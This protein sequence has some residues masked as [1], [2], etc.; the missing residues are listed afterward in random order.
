MIL[1]LN[2]FKGAGKDTAGE[3][4]V[5]RYGFELKKFADPL[6]DSCAALFGVGREDWDKW[7][8]IPTTRVKIE[9]PS[10]LGARDIKTFVNLSAREFMQ[11]FGTESHR[12][13]FG[14]DFWVDLCM[15][16][17]DPEKKTVIT[18]V[19][20]ENEFKAVRAA[21]GYVVRIER[22]E[23]VLEDDHPSEVA[24]DWTSLDFT[25][26]NDGTK[27]ELY[28]ALDSLMKYLGMEVT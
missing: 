7:K 5:E 21:K 6:Y 1:G 20:F 8:N 17:I 27:K 2:G 10:F 9:G 16:S 19:R 25:I 11:R 12:D 18:D 4:L 28:D 15:K 3:Y 26:W 23:Q 22:N 14:Q 13:I 24:P